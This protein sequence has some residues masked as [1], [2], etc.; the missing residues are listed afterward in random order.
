[1]MLSKVF[2]RKWLPITLLVLLVA[3]VC[4]SLGIWQLNRLAQRR[5]FNA[6]VHA[7]QALPPLVLPVQ[8]DLTKM[9]YRA[10]KV[11]GVYDFANQVAIRNQFS[12]NQYG[13]HLLTPLH[14]TDGSAVLI[15]RG[16]IPSEGNA[17]PG[18]WRKYD[19]PGEVAL[20]GV[21]RLSQT[22]PSFGG[23]SDPTLTPG[24]TRLEFWV[25][26]NLDRIHEQ[27]PYPILPVY[28]QLN[29]DPGRTD[30]PIPYQPV[31]D[32]SEGPHESYAIQWFSFGTLLLIGYPL[33]IRRQDRRKI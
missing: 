18:D 16:W 15:D 7:M 11:T 10:V 31:L 5:V 20:G 14:L 28:I 8:E 25:Y 27:I 6:H 2:S 9:E 30:P 13:Y 32:L 4:A 33:Y 29:P 3:V 19:Q 17:A 22:M 12:G 23:V 26:V 1:M 21:I 24:Q